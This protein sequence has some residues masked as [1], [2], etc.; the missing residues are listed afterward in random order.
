MGLYRGLRPNFLKA[1]PAIAI[2]YAVYD[3]ARAKLSSLVPK[4][5]S[6]GRRIL[7]GGDSS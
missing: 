4:Q 2:S 3:K 1:L 5:G 6:N 7:V